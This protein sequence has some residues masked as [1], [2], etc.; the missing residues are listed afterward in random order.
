MSHIKDIMMGCQLEVQKQ[1]NKGNKTV[2]KAET[3]TDGLSIN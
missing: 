3:V 2:D 1:G